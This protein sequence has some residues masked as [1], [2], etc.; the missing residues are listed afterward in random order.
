MPRGGKLT[1]ATS[2][3]H[4]DDSFVARHGCDDSAEFALITATDTGEGVAPEDLP[5]IF[6]PFFTTKVPGKGTGLGLAIIYGIIRQHNGFI[7]VD[8]VQ[9]QG[10]T[11]RI[12]L[13]LLHDQAALGHGETVPPPPHGS[14]TILLVE[15]EALVRNALR[16]V[17]CDFGYRV[18]EA[19]DGE[20][21]VAVFR[22]NAATIDLVI[23]DMIMPK[24]N[25]WE[26][27]Q[28]IR[29]LKP[30]IRNIFLSGYTADILDSK[31]IDGDTGLLVKKPVEPHVLLEAIR[32]IL[33]R[34]AAHH[35]RPKDGLTSNS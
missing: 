26:A 35:P 8:S 15:D 32:N 33:G 22:E 25:G 13:P 20:E 19:G 9:G 18:L 29:T 1:I 34:T 7:E 10:T 30:G 21:A 6:E 2:R 17:I 11:F 24:K 3:V 27:L 31:G 23:I 5:R 16:S 28:E 4:P 12:Y 14:G